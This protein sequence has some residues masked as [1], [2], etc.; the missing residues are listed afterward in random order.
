M[1]Q[2]LINKIKDDFGGIPELKFTIFIGGII[3]MAVTM[4]FYTLNFFNPSIQVPV[5]V[6]VYIV[7][8]AGYSFVKEILRWAGF[9][10]KTYIGEYL[11]LLWGLYLIILMFLEI[12]GEFKGYNW[13]VSPDLVG[14]VIEITIIYFLSIVSKYLHRKKAIGQN[15]SLFF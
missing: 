2:E 7:I 14:I 4:I 10:Q 1:I 13:K 3:W 12:F 15:K 8:V 5:G 9:Q 11:V 6:S